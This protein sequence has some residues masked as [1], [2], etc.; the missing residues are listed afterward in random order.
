MNSLWHYLLYGLATVSLWRDWPL[1]R[2]AY[3]CVCLSLLCVILSVIYSLIKIQAAH[4]SCIE[5]DTIWSPALFKPYICEDRVFWQRVLHF[6]TPCVNLHPNMAYIS[7]VFQ[8][9]SQKNRN[10]RPITLN[11]ALAQQRQIHILGNDVPIIL[12]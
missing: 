10:M 3:E 8:K 6:S 4:S 5:V 1:W 9:P 11:K 7:S 12:T 2:H